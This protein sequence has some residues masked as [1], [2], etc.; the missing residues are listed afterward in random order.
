MFAGVNIYL[1][2]TCSSPSKAEL[3]AE[4]SCKI[5]M[6]NISPNISADNGLAETLPAPAGPPR[7]Y[8]DDLI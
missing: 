4:H 6:A 5:V 7:T 3:H 2:V 1:R 8:A